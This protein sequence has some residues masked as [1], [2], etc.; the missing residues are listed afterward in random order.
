MSLIK[1]T[2]Q[3]FNRVYQKQINTMRF[4]F[5][6]KKCLNEPKARRKTD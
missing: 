6:F 1:N 4:Y 3:G 2:Q 5:V